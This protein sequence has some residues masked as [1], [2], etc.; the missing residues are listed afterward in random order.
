MIKF[1]VIYVVMIYVTMFAGFVIVS[2]IPENKRASNAGI[3][4]VIGS[5][6]WPIYLGFYVAVLALIIFF[7]I[8]RLGGKLLTNA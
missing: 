8:I 3:F 4:V 2:R 1:I 6:F 7:R 5:I